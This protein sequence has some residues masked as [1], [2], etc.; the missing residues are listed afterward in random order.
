L[1]ACSRTLFVS[2]AHCGAVLAGLS[3]FLGRGGSW[4]RQK[5]TLGPAIVGLDKT[6]GESHGSRKTRHQTP[7][8]TQEVSQ[9]DKRLFPHQE[10]AVPIRAGSRESRRSLRQA[11]PPRQQAPVPPPVDSARGRRRPPERLDLRPVDSRPESCRRQSGSQSIGGHSG[12]GR[13]DLH[14]TGGDSESR[15]PAASQG[16]K[17]VAA[18]RL[19]C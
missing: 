6:E 19:L 15:R 11:R 12:E 14:L 18:R 17:G 8:T 9:E 13:R 10:Q 16:E 2:P 4:T 1:L 3:F 5:E 7:G